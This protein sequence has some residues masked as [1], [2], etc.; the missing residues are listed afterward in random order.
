MAGVITKG[1]L[2]FT[3]ILCL[4]HTT[5][6][7]RLLLAMCQCH[8]PRVLVAVIAA[9]HRFVYVLLDE[10]ERMRRGTV[11][12]ERSIVRAACHWLPFG[13]GRGPSVCCSCGAASELNAFTRR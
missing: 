11:L 7:E 13:T 4:A 3:V 8:I 12:R 5:S 2:S 6:F 1:L 10:L 9:M